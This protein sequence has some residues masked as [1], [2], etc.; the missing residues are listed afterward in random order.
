MGTEKWLKYTEDEY[1]DAIPGT[2]GI[3]AQIA[4][5]LTCSRT[6]IYMAI[7]KYPKV[8]ECL[9]LERDNLLDSAEFGITHNIRVRNAKAI[10]TGK[11]ID[12]SDHKWVLGRKS[13]AYAEKLDVTS[14]QKPIFADVDPAKIDETLARLQEIVGILSEK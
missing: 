3:I 5:N 10:N 13:L 6:T 4:K 11:A 2:C 9:Q 12:T 8:A 14:A 1:L 7:D